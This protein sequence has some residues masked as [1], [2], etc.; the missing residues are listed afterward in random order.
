MASSEPPFPLPLPA[1][2]V[3][4]GLAGGARIAV[5][6]PGFLLCRTSTDAPAEPAGE[7]EILVL[8]TE[9]VR[10]RGGVTAERTL[11]AATDQRGRSLTVEHWRY[12]ASEAVAVLPTGA[13]AALVDTCT[14]A[15][16]GRRSG[17][18]P[19]PPPPARAD[20]AV[21]VLAGRHPGTGRCRIAD[22]VAEVEL[23]GLDGPRELPAAA[24]P[25]WLAGL[26]GL[27]PRPRAEVRGLLVTSRTALA[28]P[29]RLPAGW[30]GAPAAHWRLDLTVPGAGPSSLEVLDAGSLWA[31]SPVEEALLAAE[32]VAVDGEPVAVRPT[33][34]S[35]VWRWLAPLA[36]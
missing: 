11:L 16:R 27:G 31:L 35:A 14:A 22:G 8:D 28:E 5:G 18:A 6:G 26:V 17:A 32:E 7:A 23:P 25:G 24:L 34:P 3:D 2:W 29:G 13:Y 36:A 30:A 21:T 1:G 10:C 33:T 4:R 19:V 12:P 9:P 15:L 20:L